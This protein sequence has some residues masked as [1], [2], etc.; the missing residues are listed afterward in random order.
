MNIEHS[1]DDWIAR[2]WPGI[3]RD[4]GSVV[5][6]VEASG[7]SSGSTCIIVAYVNSIIQ[8]IRFFACFLV[9]DEVASCRTTESAQLLSTLGAINLPQKILS[10]GL[11]IGRRRSC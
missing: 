8:S 9:Y 1:R 11:R 3:V 7:S 10:G 5:N 2:G 6:R 4:K